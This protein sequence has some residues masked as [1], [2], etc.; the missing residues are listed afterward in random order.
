VLHTGFLVALTSC[1]PVFNR[2]A[3]DN[4]YTSLTSDIN[5]RIKFL[6]SA[7]SFAL[8][9]GYENANRGVSTTTGKEVTRSKKIRDRDGKEH[10][11][12]TTP[13][14]RKGKVWD[15]NYLFGGQLV[16]LIKKAEAAI[17]SGF[18]LSEKKRTD[19]GFKH[20]RKP[21]NK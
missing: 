4:L 21:K 20:A 9:K 13:E 19:S 12:F 5:D 1:I 15:G 14:P 6:I 10:T 8:S 2:L 11:V 7:A 3:K 17:K 18:H 16:A